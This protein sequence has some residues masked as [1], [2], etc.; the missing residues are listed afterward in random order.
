MRLL[1]LDTF[2][3]AARHSASSA[4]RS[5]APPCSRRILHQRQLGGLEHVLRQDRLPGEHVAVVHGD[6]GDAFA[7][8]AEDVLRHHELLH[9]LV[10]ADAGVQVGEVEPAGD[11]RAP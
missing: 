7:E 4:R 5:I 10:T 8:L 2:M 6:A 3:P 1:K 11:A 9:A